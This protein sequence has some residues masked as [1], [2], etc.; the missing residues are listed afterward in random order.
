MV[1]GKFASQ[2]PDEPLI[3][4]RLS[5]SDNITSDHSQE[6]TIFKSGASS[7]NLL[8]FD[9]P[10]P[11]IPG[12]TGEMESFFEIRLNAV[13]SQLYYDMTANHPLMKPFDFGLAVIGSIGTRD[14][15]DFYPVST[16]NSGMGSPT[17][18]LILFFRYESPG[19][20][21]PSRSRPLCNLG[22]IN[23]SR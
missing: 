16:L 22:T 20:T 12:P 2:H 1:Y 4:A 8:F 6:P 7:P 13:V 9:I 18:S 10:Y 3:E 23:T 21:V 15:T 5:N 17:K 14:Q 11:Q 19:L